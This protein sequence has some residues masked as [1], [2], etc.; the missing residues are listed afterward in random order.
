[1]KKVW[2]TWATWADCV[3]P[4]TEGRGL[5]EG[6]GL[7]AVGEG[8]S[9]EDV[10]GAKEC[11]PTSGYNGFT[12]IPHYSA[13]PCSHMPAL[14]VPPP[15]GAEARRRGCGDHR[16]ELCVPHVKVP[17]VH[18]ARGLKA[19]TH[20]CEGKSER[21]DAMW[22]ALPLNSEQ[23]WRSFAYGPFINV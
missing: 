13:Y 10:Q 15:T 14:T 5:P 8:K 20:R 7:V 11:M 1:M 9:E 17:G 6:G 3:V 16:H 2:S 22:V 18:S 23:L 12:P 21:D 4:V 19:V